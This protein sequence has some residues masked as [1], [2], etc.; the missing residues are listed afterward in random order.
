MPADGPLPADSRSY[1]KHIIELRLALGLRIGT[2]GGRY[3]ASRAT[4]VNMR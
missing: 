4:T 1:I 2:A 3:T